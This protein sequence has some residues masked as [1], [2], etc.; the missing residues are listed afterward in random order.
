MCGAL[1]GESTIIA[2]HKAR[3]SP[4]QH[5]ARGVFQA[6]KKGLSSKSCQEHKVPTAAAGEPAAPISP[7]FASLCRCMVWCRPVLHG[8][9][10]WGGSVMP[11]VPPGKYF[12]RLTRNKHLVSL[13]PAQIHR[14]WRGLP[15]NLDSVDAVYERTS[16][17]KIVFFKGESKRRCVP[18]GHSLAVGLCSCRDPRAHLLPVPISSQ[19][20]Q[21][22][23][24]E[25]EDRD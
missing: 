21:F 7:R 13:Q 4:R 5:S 8:G 3:L 18:P 22:L 16:D 23:L 6:L 17:H 1:W 15:L 12:W 2:L 11:S 9:G 24:Q 25:L 20:L 14:F 10:H 19:C